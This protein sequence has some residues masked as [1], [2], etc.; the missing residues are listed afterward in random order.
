MLVDIG[1]KRKSSIPKT[2]RLISRLFLNHVERGWKV[3]LVGVP[4]FKENGSKLP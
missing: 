1:L 3:N 2:Y 4:S